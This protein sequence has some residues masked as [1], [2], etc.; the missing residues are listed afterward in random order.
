M[1]TK[2]LID[3]KFDF[4]A[5]IYRNAKGEALKEKS[6]WDFPCS[7]CGSPAEMTGCDCYYEYYK[8]LNCGKTTNVN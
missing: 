1:G 2:K 8:C 4:D 3:A 6:N 7:K 5:Q